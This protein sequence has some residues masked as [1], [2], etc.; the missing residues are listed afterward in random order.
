MHI[1]TQ[2][3]ILSSTHVPKRKRRR[4]RR[5]TLPSQAILLLNQTSLWAVCAHE[6]NKLPVTPCGPCC[7]REL[8]KLPS[9][10]AFPRCVRDM[11]C[12]SATTADTPTVA[13]AWRAAAAPARAGQQLW[14]AN[15]PNL[16][17][18][19]TYEPA[20]SCAIHWLGQ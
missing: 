2:L 6:L 12:S 20:Q 17:T 18:A 15:Y 16:G 3:D 8:S 19:E 4:T 5:R 10:R 11:R 13:A 14:Y 7:A 9:G 1:S